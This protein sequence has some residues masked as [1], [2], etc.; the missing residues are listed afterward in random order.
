M[1]DGTKIEWTEATWNPITGCSVVSPGC[2]NC[3]AMRLAGTRLQ[4]H[5]SRAGLTRDTKAGPAW[6][7]EVRFNEEWLDQPLRRRRPRMIFVCAHGDLFHE[8][9]PDEWIDQAF[10][11]MWMAEQHTFQVLTKRPARM[12][13]YLQRRLQTSFKPAL[14]NVWLGVSAEDQARADERI[15]I[16]LDTPAAVRWLSAEPL[17]GAIDL[18][19]VFPSRSPEPPRDWEQEL[20]W[21]VIG[22]ESGKGARAVWMP[23]VRRLVRQCRAAGVATFVKQLGAFVTD[24]NDAGFDGC[25]DESWPEQF[26]DGE[27]VEH[28][29]DGY[30]DDYQGAPVRVHLRDPK[31]GDPAEWPTDLRVRE[32]PRA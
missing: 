25:E 7:G 8:A 17:L 6:T 2:T 23:N 26:D 5:P 20:D 22:G 12:R 19:R 21:V 11:V 27:R 16:L 30:R 29:L 15:P 9:V 3:Y 13:S 31:G 14:P 1:A 10:A 4:H 24:R 28:N 18:D 32:W